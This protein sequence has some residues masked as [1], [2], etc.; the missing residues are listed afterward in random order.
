MA[1][2]G[3]TGSKSLKKWMI[4]CRVPRLLRDKLPVIADRDGAAAAAGIGTAGRCAAKPGEPCLR[5][6]CLRR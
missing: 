1:L 2:A 4:E 6:E 5:V 3:R